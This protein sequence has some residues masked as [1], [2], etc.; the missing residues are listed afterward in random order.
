MLKKVSLPRGLWPKRVDWMGRVVEI[1]VSI[2]DNISIGS[3]LVD[4][5]I[6]KA[7]L[8]LES[9]VDGVVKNVFVSVGDE[10]SPGTTLLEIEV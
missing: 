8:T 1:Y 3:P 2:G 7:I 5:E 9:D 4:V 6:E 10:V